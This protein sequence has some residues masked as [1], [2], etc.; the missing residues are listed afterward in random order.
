L[1]GQHRRRSRDFLGRV[2]EKW[3]VKCYYKTV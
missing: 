3:K 2:L 1:Y